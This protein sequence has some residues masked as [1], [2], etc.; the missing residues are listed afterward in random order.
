VVDHGED[1]AE[2]CGERDEHT[3]NDHQPP[4][5]VPPSDAVAAPMP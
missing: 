1:R 3:D 5:P 4:A 2:H